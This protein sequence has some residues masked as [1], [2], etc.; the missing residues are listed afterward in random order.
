MKERDRQLNMM[1]LEVIRIF[2]TFTLWIILAIK[3]SQKKKDYKKNSL[4]T[5]SHTHQTS[6][7]NPNSDKSRGGGGVTN[8][9]ES[10]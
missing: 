1:I 8:P 7:Q 5:P 9:F 2:Q 10:K 4:W 3:A 6:T